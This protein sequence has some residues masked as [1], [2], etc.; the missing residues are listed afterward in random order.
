LKEWVEN[1]GE[2]TAGRGSEL[3]DQERVLPWPWLINYIRKPFIP[4]CS[5]RELFPGTSH[6]GMIFA[7]FLRDRRTDGL[8]ARDSRSP[9]PLVSHQSSLP[10][11]VGV[12]RRSPS[13]GRRLSTRIS[14]SGDDRRLWLWNEETLKRNGTVSTW[15]FF[16][17]LTA[18]RDCLSRVDC[19]Q[20]H[21]RPEQWDIVCWVA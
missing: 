7:P 21:C 14:R 12:P 20:P 19:R 15:K 18:S 2:G 8:S 16:Y 17:T 6:F 13:H 4:P 10:L 9:L 11:P 1:S 5:L 3:T